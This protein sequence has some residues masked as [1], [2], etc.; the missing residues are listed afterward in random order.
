M[1][2]HV[3]MCPACLRVIDFEW[4][5]DQ[6]IEKVVCGNCTMPFNIEEAERYFRLVKSGATFSDKEFMDYFNIRRIRSP[7]PKTSKKEGFLLRVLR[8]FVERLRNIMV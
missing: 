4:E 8:S 7:P 1:S 6:P 2:R 5:G 3:V